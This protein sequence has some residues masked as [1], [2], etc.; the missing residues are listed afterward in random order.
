MV[1][2]TKGVESGI[3][4]KGGEALEKAHKITA[5]AFD[6]TG[7]LTK[8]EPAVTDAIPYGISKEDLIFYA[9]IAE[10]ASEHPLAKA[11]AKAGAELGKIIPE[12]KDGKAVT[13]MGIRATHE[14]K[15]IHVGNDTLMTQN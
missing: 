12:P 3:L 2:T 14:G 9:A 1:G 15:E 6:K 5:V 13:G 7:T 11:V 4:I 10:K 8:G